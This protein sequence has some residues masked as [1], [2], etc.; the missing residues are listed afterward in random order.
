MFYKVLCEDN[1]EIVHLTGRTDYE[2]LTNLT[3]SP[4]QNTWKNLE[5]QFL[6][7]D[8][9][10]KKMYSDFPWYMSSVLILRENVVSKMKSFFEKNGELLPMHSVDNQKLYAF[11]CKI[12]DALDE[13]KSD[14]IRL[15]SSGKIVLVKKIAFK[16]EKLVNVDIFRLNYPSSPTFVSEEFIKLYNEYK[17]VGLKFIK[18]TEVNLK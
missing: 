14:I 12:I 8:T 3:G 15:K 7:A 18:Y 9:G 11:N 10:K 13:E 4:V 16:D 2:F 5:I 17:F 1:Y 6:S